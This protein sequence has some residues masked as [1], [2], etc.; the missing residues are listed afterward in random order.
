MSQIW[1]KRVFYINSGNQLTGSENTFRVNLNI[2]EWGEYNRVTCLQASIPVSYYCIQNT[3][4]TFTL[5][6]G[7]SQVVVTMTPG[8]YNIN[9]FSTILQ[10][11]LNLNSPNGYTYQVKYPVSYTQPDTGKFVFSV[12][13][14]G[15][16]GFIFPPESP[17]A[18]Q[19]GFDIG[20]TVYFDSGFLT[21][22]NVVSFIPENAIFIHSNIVDGENDSDVLQ[23]IYSN[24]S[25]PFSLCTYV[26]PDPL[27][28]SKKILS[29]KVRN[30]SFS[31]TNEYNQPLYLNGQDI[32]LTIMLYKDSDF[33]EKTTS[34]YGGVKEYIK[35]QLQRDNPQIGNE[36]EQEA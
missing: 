35:Y 20:E 23:E 29:N 7:S 3:F 13:N 6:E 11:L 30:V 19:F 17:I 5:F 15:S 14:T 9:S 32:L 12:S 27:S 2:P 25:I 31:I 10:G 1:K 18:D 34:F 28:N 36:D 4:N 24:N 22:Q 8:N 26:N 33:Y 21:S 16:I